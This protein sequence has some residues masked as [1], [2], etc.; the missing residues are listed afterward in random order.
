MDWLNHENHGRPS[1]YNFWARH[2]GGGI[3]NSL[4]LMALNKCLDMTEHQS[5]TTEAIILQIS[6]TRWALSTFVTLF[7]HPQ[8]R[9]YFHTPSITETME[10]GKVCPPCLPQDFHLWKEAP[11]RFW[12]SWEECH[13]KAQ[14]NDS[15]V[16]H[17]LNSCRNFSFFHGKVDGH[18]IHHGRWTFCHPVILNRCSPLASFS[19]PHLLP[20][21]PLVPFGALVSHEGT[22]IE[23]Q[24]PGFCD[25]RMAAISCTGLE[26][27]CWILCSGA[28]KCSLVIFL[29]IGCLF[30]KVLSFIICFLYIFFLIKIKHLLKVHRKHP[31]SHG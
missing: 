18:R 23:Q 27:I 6:G 7:F 8:T 2:R 11:A 10:R 25:K 30:F 16:F 15:F 28:S 22:I 4:G 26:F 9:T 17:P 14:Q 21:L 20:F 3:I 13:E 24:L 31:F 12:T 29:F 5:I 19:G 1:D